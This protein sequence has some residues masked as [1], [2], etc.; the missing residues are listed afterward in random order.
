M[1]YP[2]PSCVCQKK[3][4]ILP[5][6]EM[7]LHEAGELVDKA[8]QLLVRASGDEDGQQFVAAEALDKGLAGALVGGAIP[9][10]ADGSG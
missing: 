8:G 2:F 1:L 4:V 3:P 7:S 6:R 10:E 9:A 5:F